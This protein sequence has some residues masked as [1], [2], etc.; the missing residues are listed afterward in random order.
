MKTARVIPAAAAIAYVCLCDLSLAGQAPGGNVVVPP[1]AAKGQRANSEVVRLESVK[2]ISE[3]RV[4][5]TAAVKRLSSELD[6]S[7]AEK[8]KVQRERDDLAR[9]KTAL[10]AERD[11]LL[12]D[13][14]RLT[15]EKSDL[16]ARI[17]SLKIQGT[18]ISNA[19]SLL[20][21]KNR[22]LKV[23]KAELENTKEVLGATKATLAREIASQQN[24]HGTLVAD[25]ERLALSNSQLAKE[26][27]DLQS[28]TAELKRQR[29]DL[30][31]DLDWKGLLVKIFS[32]STV[33]GVLA[34]LGFMVSRRTT[35]LQNERLELENAGLKRELAKDKVG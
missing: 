27:T 34:V 24:Q 17:D 8:N 11:M 7:I 32:G 13:K 31:K 21:A 10:A 14:E 9:Q 4:A 30:T 16:T 23:T 12:A 6:E 15:R 2:T 29:D 25:N 18:E 3:L 20:E 28:F 5:S 19:N 35:V 33:T 26:K 1:P 22:E